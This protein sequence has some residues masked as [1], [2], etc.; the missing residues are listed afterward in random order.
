VQLGLDLFAAPPMPGR[1]LSPEEKARLRL[2]EA[3]RIQS[4][5]T[6][7][8]LLDQGDCPDATRCAR[9]VNS[10]LR[11]IA[12]DKPTVTVERIDEAIYMV[13]GYFSSLAS[14]ETYPVQRKL[15]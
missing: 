13:P 4:V 2:V 1:V 8:R 10:I 5:P 11:G 14:G 12:S 7:E 3:V 9:L 15:L 6:A